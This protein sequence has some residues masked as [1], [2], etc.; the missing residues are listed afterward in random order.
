MNCCL[1]KLNR[2]RMVRHKGDRDD[3]LYCSPKILLQKQNGHAVINE[4]VGHCDEV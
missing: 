1:L 4:I 2:E 3:S